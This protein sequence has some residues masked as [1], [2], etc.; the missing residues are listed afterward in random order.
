MRWPSKWAP[1]L[2]LALGFPGTILTSAYVCKALV[3]QGVFSERVGFFLF[4]S[5]A[6]VLLLAMVSYALS[7]KKRR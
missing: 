2:G 4:F 1:L 3:D 5:L 7:P 6:F